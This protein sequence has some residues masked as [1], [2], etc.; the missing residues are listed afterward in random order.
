MHEKVTFSSRPFH[1]RTGV[2]HDT[3]KRGPLNSLNQSNHIDAR[4]P[5]MGRAEQ[6]HSLKRQHSGSQYNTIDVHNRTIVDMVNRSVVDVVS[7]TTPNTVVDDQYTATDLGQQQERGGNGRG[8]GGGMGSRSS[9]CA[10]FE[11]DE[12]NNNNNTNNEKHTDLENNSNTNTNTTNNYDRRVSGMSRGTGGTGNDSQRSFRGLL[13]S[14]FSTVRSSFQRR[15]SRSQSQQQSQTQQ[16]DHDDK[17]LDVCRL[18]EARSK[19]IGKVEEPNMIKLLSHWT[20]TILN[21]VIYDVV[22]WLTLAMY[23]ALRIWIQIGAQHYVKGYEED[24]YDP[25]TQYE[26][27]HTTNTNTTTTAMAGTT[28]D[29]IPT[30]AATVVVTDLETYESKAKGTRN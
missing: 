2:K 20:G 23:V 28:G 6:T 26:D 16:E 12:Y 21:E 5:D 15:N 14:Q 18:D 1:D 10:S 9:S 7:G 25:H 30:A 29:S 27:G 11:K 19:L 24:T 4:K 13:P 8:G 22:F 17:F 3:Y